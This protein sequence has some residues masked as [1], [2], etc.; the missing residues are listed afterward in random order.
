MKILILN[1][2]FKVK[3]YWRNSGGTLRQK[4]NSI[5][6]SNSSRKS[7]SNGSSNS[8]SNRVIRVFMILRVLRV[9][10]VIRVLMVL[11]ILRVLR[12][13]RVKSPKDQLLAICIQFSKRKTKYNGR[14]ARNLKKLVPDQ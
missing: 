12:V 3:N 2:Q 8:K 6:S 7:V 1:S 5:N 11:M 13:L 14:N 10:R 4:E 9:L